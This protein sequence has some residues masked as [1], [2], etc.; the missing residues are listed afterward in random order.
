MTSYSP[1]LLKLLRYCK[2][3]RVNGYNVF[4]LP[5]GFFTKEEIEDLRK[6]DEARRYFK[7]KPF[8]ANFLPDDIR[9][10]GIPKL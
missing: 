5:E 7:K 3:I 9:P 4:P 10:K 2:P 1:A 8:I 6:E